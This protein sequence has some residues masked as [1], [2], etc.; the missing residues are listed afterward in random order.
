MSYFYTHPQISHRSQKL[1][2]E[3]TLQYTFHQLVFICSWEAITVS[4]F[5]IYHNTALFC[6][7]LQNMEPHLKKAV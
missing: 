1:D 6:F 5:S 7:V 4:V 2:E 3:D